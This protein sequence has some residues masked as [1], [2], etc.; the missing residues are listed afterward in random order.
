ML[1]TSV[2]SHGHNLLRRATQFLGKVAMWLFVISVV[3]I[4]DVDAQQIDSASQNVHVHFETPQGYTQGFRDYLNNLASASTGSAGPI[5]NTGSLTTMTDFEDL[6]TF[7]VAFDGGDDSGSPYS[8]AIDALNVV[9]YGDGEEKEDTEGSLSDWRSAEALRML[10][11]YR[12][13]IDK[14]AAASSNGSWPDD[15]NPPPGSHGRPPRKRRNGIGLLYGLRMIER[16]DP[17]FMYGTGGIIGDFRSQTIADNHVMGPALG[18]IWLKTRGPLTTKLQGLVSMGFNSGE[19][20]QENSIG[21]ELVPGATNRL[22]NAQP[23]YS[24]HRYSHDEFSPNGELRAEANLQIT[25]TVAF[26]INWSGIAI[27]NA[28]LA[29]DRVRF[30]LPD[31]GFRDPGDQRLI[32]HHFFCGIEVVR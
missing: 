12:T 18:M 13:G 30:Y 1:F 22:L 23:S 28:L 27:N 31:M 19:V 9:W 21:V 25:E 29:D 20:D 14:N 3:Q 26:A 11:W 8:G 2:N 5:A 16:E 4:A 15:P 10:D 17:F 7:N 24:S 6:H 32:V